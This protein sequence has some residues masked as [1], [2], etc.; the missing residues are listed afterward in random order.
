MS[1]NVR[2]GLTQAHHDIDGNEPIQKHKDSAIQKHLKL[3]EEAASKGVQIICF[4]ELFFCPYFC[5]EQNTKWFTA[6]EKIP[7][8]PTIKL[9]Q[10]QAKRH[11]MVIIVPMYEE[12]IPGVYYN[13]AAVID[14]DGSY[15]GKYHKTHIPQ[16]A[17]TGTYGFWEK[18]YFRPGNS[19]WP[20]FETAYAKIGIFICYDRYYPECA[21]ILGLK[22]A[23]VLF[24]PSSTSPA[25]GT[26]K[27]N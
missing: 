13:T 25:S 14:A 12:Q 11:S 27:A 10:E 23:E 17:A 16:E 26:T 19:D 4:Q 5:A 8:G 20:V 21:R 7:E 22:G 15:L 9:M 1:R 18:Y 2:C 6:A 24:N 3:I